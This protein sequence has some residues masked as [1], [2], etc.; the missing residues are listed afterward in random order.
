MACSVYISVI[1]RILIFKESREK[2]TF[3]VLLTFTLLGL[4]PP[5]K[6]IPLFLLTTPFLPKI[7]D[8][9]TSCNFWE[10]QYPPL[11]GGAHY[12]HPALSDTPQFH[13]NGHNL[14]F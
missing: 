2:L 11:G 5:F 4:I 3:S 10:G 9:P 8:P 6:M 1:K 12:D 14:V 13:S 7:F